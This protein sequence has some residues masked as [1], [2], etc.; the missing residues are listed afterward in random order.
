MQFTFSTSSSISAESR[1]ISPPI[2][3]ES[4]KARRFFFF[5][6]PFISHMLQQ[7]KQITFGSKLP[8]L[9]VEK[10]NTRMEFCWSDPDFL[11]FFF[12]FYFTLFCIF[13]DGIR[14]SRP[15]MVN[16]INWLFN[17][18]CLFKKQEESLSKTKQ[19]QLQWLEKLYSIKRLLEIGLL[20]FFIQDLDFYLQ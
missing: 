11:T 10:Q 9:K 7:N 12:F 6:W 4:E 5:F 2:A 17:I 13:P 8:Q 18:A 16:S 15:R 19:N 14:P 20:H 1:M 3:I